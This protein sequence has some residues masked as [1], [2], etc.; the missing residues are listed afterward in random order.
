MKKLFL[1][2][3]VSFPPVME[4][5][6][7]YKVCYSQEDYV[8]GKWETVDTL[9][10]V[11]HGK[12]HQLW[13]GG[14]DFTMK[15]GDKNLDKAIKKDVFAVMMYDSLYVN[16]RPLRYE[17]T[18]FGNGYTKGMPIGEHSILIVNRMIGK[19]AVNHAISMGFFFGIAGGMI[20]A[21]ENMKQQ[22]CYVISFGANEKGQVDIRLVDDQMI[23]MMLKGQDQLLRDYYAE[24]DADLR[25]LATVALEF[26]RRYSCINNRTEIWEPTRRQESRIISFIIQ[27]SYTYTEY[28]SPSQ[29]KHNG[30]Q[31]SPPSSCTVFICKYSSN[32]GQIT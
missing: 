29:A 25:M 18:R 23:E 3:L 9:Y 17:K 6:A 21:N 24:E 12:G 22:V 30:L 26:S 27:L 19:N 32:S 31:K 2:L 28:L 20:A 1:L 7:Q 16:C 10:A 5:L 8:E 14:N 4:A 13:W 15:S 11:H